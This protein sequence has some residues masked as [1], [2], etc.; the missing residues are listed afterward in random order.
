MTRRISVPLAAS[1]TDTHCMDCPAYEWGTDPDEITYY[2]CGAFDKPLEA[3]LVPMRAPLRGMR[4]RGVRLLECVQAER[5]HAAMVEA[6]S[7]AYRRALW[8]VAIGAAVD[9]DIAPRPSSHWFRHTL[10]DLLRRATTGEVQR[11]I[12]GHATREMSE[13]YSHVGR[14]EK[15]A[16]LTAALSLARIGRGGSDAT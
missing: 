10:N 15:R 4:I 13:H 7:A 12:T 16:G 2:H 14:D 6:P 9:A 1:T 3:V 5:E 11:A 8:M